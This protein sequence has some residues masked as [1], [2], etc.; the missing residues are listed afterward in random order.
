ML[1]MGFINILKNFPSK[2]AI[3]VW[4]SNSV[5]TK[6]GKSEGTTEVA[7]RVNPV[8]AATKLD[9]ENITKLNVKSKNIPGNK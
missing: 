9:D 7:H 3:L 8:L 1:N 6:K 5:A 2:W 4:A